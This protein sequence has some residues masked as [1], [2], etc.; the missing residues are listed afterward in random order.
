MRIIFSRKGVDSGTTPCTKPSPAFSDGS[1]VSIPIP[2]KHSPVRYKDV[3]TPKGNL[4][5]I[6]STLMNASS[7]EF[8]H[9]DPD[10][11][12]ASRATRHPQWR[13]AFGQ[14]SGALT[15]LNKQGVTEGDLF[16]FYGR[17]KSVVGRPLRYL[18][19]PDFKNGDF[20][21]VWGWL[22]V[23]AR[24]DLSS[25]TIPP[26]NADHPHACGEYAGGNMVY[27]ASDSL[28][29]PS[30]ERAPGG[31]VL[32]RLRPLTLHGAAASKWRIDRR[33][34]TQHR[35]EYVGDCERFPQL[36]DIACE[37]LQDLRLADVPL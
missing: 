37:M 30:L 35:Q 23:G 9:L 7:E 17:F 3:T 5:T 6:V 4:G 21:A 19:H 26:G 31:G 2:S 27:I 13:P 18:A 33:M 15:H 12:P 22:P 32:P 14:N 20:Q 25:Q 1:F 11:D 8:A 34:L 16:L 28:G 10:L 24:I 29:L 36:L